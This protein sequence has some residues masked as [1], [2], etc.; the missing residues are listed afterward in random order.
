MIYL[1]FLVNLILTVIIEGVLTAIIF[2]RRDYVYYS[3]LCNMLTN[4]ALNLILLVLV[5][6]GGLDYYY[7]ALI[8]L[9]IIAVI[10]EAGIWKLLCRFPIP[11]ALAFS[12]LLNLASFSA[13]LY[14]YNR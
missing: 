9:E 14:L 1:Y 5:A 12:L 13:G 7:V 4:P 11:K 6:K 10:V 2:R 3:F 8:I